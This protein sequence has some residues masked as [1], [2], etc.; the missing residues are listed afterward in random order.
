ME[1]RNRLRFRRREIGDQRR[2]SGRG[3]DGAGIDR[4]GAGC[5]DQARDVGFAMQ[6]AVGEESENDGAAATERDPVIDRITPILTSAACSIR[7]SGDRQEG[8][9]SVALQR[10]LIQETPQHVPMQRQLKGEP[11]NAVPSSI[12]QAR[13][14]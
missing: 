14:R 8:D 10:R 4:F 6:A 11:N 7:S 13:G 1:K 2:N 9:P 12:G 5:R 3:A